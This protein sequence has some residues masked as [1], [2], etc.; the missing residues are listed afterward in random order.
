[1]I[2]LFFHLNLLD[3][4]MFT[5]TRARGVVMT[6][7]YLTRSTQARKPL[8]PAADLPDFFFLN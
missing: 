5:G 4:D 2:K 1:M 3:M 6:V 7:K 8:F